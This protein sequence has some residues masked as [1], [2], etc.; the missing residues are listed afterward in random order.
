MIRPHWIS[1]SLLSDA[2]F[3]SGE[4]T[5]GEVHIEIDHDE[6]G[7]PYLRGR[8]IRGLLRDSWLTMAAAFPELERAALRV[9]G[10][11]GDLEE[12]SIVRIGDG[13]IDDTVRAVVRQAVTRSEHP[14]SP[15]EILESLT[16]VRVQAAETRDTGAT[17]PGTLRMTR[18]LLRGTML[19]ASLGWLATP[20]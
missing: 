17:T 2:T 13:R 20:D 3:G 4:T 8:T 1:V 12:T 16:D 18:V 15:A 6:L 5:P 14:L 7:L 10:P 11:A 19:H 9:L